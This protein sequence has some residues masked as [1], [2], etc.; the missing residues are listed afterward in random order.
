LKIGELAGI[1]NEALCAAWELARRNTRLEEA[2]L[3]VTE[4]PVTGFCS[5]CQSER[6]VVSSRDFRCAQC[7]GAIDRVVAG[8]ELEVEALEIES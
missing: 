3:V 2:S 8:R 1:V 7:G 5:T 6:D 4:I